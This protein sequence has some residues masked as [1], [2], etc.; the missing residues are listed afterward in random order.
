GLVGFVIGDL[1]LFQ[2][3]VVI[4]SRIS[5]LIM[6]L[7]PPM[8]AMIGWIWL[9]ETLGWIELAGMTLT[10]TGIVTVV[11]R[12]N[13]NRRQDEK[14][15]PGILLALGGALGQAI[16]LVLSKFGMGDYNAFAATQIRILAGIAG[17]TILFAG[18]GGWSRLLRATRDRGAMKRITLGS[19]FGPF[20][21]VSFSL[22]AVQHTL[23]GVASTIM[24]IVPILIIPPSVVLFKERV[25]AWEVAGAIM[26]VTGVA[27]LFL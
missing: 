25:T 10:V 27:V 1:L 5:M 2:A 11:S 4:G 20:L 17:F 22:V 21:G 26:A 8:T 15:L 23:T 12:R 19:F 7:V 18:L 6:A 24:A 14:L 9:G 3:F 16:G 13:H